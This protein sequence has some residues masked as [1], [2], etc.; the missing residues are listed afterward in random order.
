MVSSRFH[1]K[2]RLT[3]KY[4]SVVTTAFY[5]PGNLATALTEFMNM[6]STARASNFVKGLRIR[7]THLGYRKT[8]KGVHKDTAK[9]YIFESGELGKLSVEEFFRRSM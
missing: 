3:H 7:A 1:A 8:I 2:S 4:H 5:K 9:S 6:G